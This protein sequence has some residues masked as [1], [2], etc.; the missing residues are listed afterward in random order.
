MHTKKFLTLM[1]AFILAMGLFSGCSNTEETYT[2]NSYTPSNVKITAINI[3]VR[4]REIEVSL[5]QDGQIHISYFESEKEFYDISISSDNVLS[6]TAMTNKKWTDYVGSKPA[7][8]SRKIRLQIPD[9]LISSLTLTTTNENIILSELTVIDDIIL[10]TNG[11]DINIE[12][13][14]AGNLIKLTAKNGDIEGSIVGGYDDFAIVS[15][16]KKG[17]NNLPSTKSGGDKTLD[18]SNNNGNIDIDFERS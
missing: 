9:S 6:M 8:G 1:A 18:V 5:S 11:G 4:D 3:D 2:E 15:K 16:I 7:A 17:K 10:S 14:N 13:I 12:R